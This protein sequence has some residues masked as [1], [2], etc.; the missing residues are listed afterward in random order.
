MDER[1][2]LVAD[3][4][5]SADHFNFESAAARGENLLPACAQGQEIYRSEGDD[6]TTRTE[7]LDRLNEGKLLVNYIGHGSVE[8]WRGDS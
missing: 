2:V 4:M 1:V 3:K 6:G 8:L 7:I 5:E